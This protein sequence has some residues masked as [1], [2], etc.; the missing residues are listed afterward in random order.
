M[1][2]FVTY[3]L[4]LIGVVAYFYANKFYWTFFSVESASISD[5]TLCSPSRE[6]DM[7]SQAVENNIP[8]FT[9]VFGCFLILQICHLLSL[10]NAI[11]HLLVPL[12]AVIRAALPILAFIFVYLMFLCGWAAFFHSWCGEL[13]EFRD[14]K[15]SLLFCIKVSAGD[16]DVDVVFDDTQFEGIVDSRNSLCASFNLHTR[17]QHTTQKSNLNRI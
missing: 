2:E 10:F 11:P 13:P 5:E 12:Q 6:I 3:E 8:S 7:K 4:I 1:E 16:F 17:N 15:R 14:F 9:F